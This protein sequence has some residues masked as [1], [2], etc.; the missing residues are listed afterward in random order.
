M[1]SDIPVTLMIPATKLSCITGVKLM[2]VEESYIISKWRL[3]NQMRLGFSRF[4]ESIFH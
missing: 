3:P 1:N 2:I 4:T